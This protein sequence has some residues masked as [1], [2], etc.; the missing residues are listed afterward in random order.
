MILIICVNISLK[1][2]EKHSKLNIT[3]D[4]ILSA[5]WTAIFLTQ[6]DPG[7]PRTVLL[8]FTAD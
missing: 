7:Q 1:A 8:S 5:I 2:V 3:I 4:V 6:P